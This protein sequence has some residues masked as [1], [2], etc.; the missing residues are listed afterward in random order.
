MK[1]MPSI[2]F[3]NSPDIL[4]IHLLIDNYFLG[5]DKYGNDWYAKTLSNGTQVWTQ[6]R[7]AQIRNG[8]INQPP[9]PIS[10]SNQIFIA[11]QT[12]TIVRN[13]SYE[14]TDCS[15][16]FCRNARVFG[17]LLWT[18]SVGWSW[19]IIGGYSTVGRWYDSRTCR[20]NAIKLSFFVKATIF[21]AKVFARKN[22]CF[23]R[24]APIM[25]GSVG[26]I[27]RASP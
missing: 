5:T 27:P 3:V 17:K 23:K 6:V 13:I 24:I 2:S 10:P 16:S 12:P 11:H 14:N 7:K 4:R 21:E 25:D 20:F 15:R 19:C 1:E 22:F 26:A 8:G 18:N 9:P